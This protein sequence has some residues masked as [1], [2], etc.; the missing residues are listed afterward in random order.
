MNAGILVGD[1][2][3]I[4]HGLAGA[5]QANRNRRVLIAERSATLVGDR[6]GVLHGLAGAWQFGTRI[7]AY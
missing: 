7:G 1:R 3:P 2:L 4:S 6:L 5:C